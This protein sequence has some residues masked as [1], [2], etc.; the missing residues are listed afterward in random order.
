MDLLLVQRVRRDTPGETR[1]LD[2]K[3]P[4]LHR[5]V[6]ELRGLIGQ[7]REAVSSAPAHDRFCSVDA[8]SDE[9][10]AFSDD[11]SKFWTAVLLAS[12]GPP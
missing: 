1:F 8:A 3:H 9:N 5:E 11:F 10:S 6:F 2:A 12:A 7:A 4:E